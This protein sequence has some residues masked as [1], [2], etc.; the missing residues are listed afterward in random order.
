[1]TLSEKISQSKAELKESQRMNV[2]LELLTFYDE[3]KK[4]PSDKSFALTIPVTIVAANESFFKETF[5]GLIDFD[6]KFLE[7]AKILI[8]KAGIKFELDELF[9]I[10]KSSFSLGD[11][12]SYTLKYSSIESLLKTFQVISEIDIFRE[13]ETFDASMLEDINDM[14]SVQRPLNK[15]RI[16]TNLKEAYEIRNIICHDFLSSTHKLELDNEKLA[17]F[18]LDAALLQYAIDDI[19]SDKIYSKG[20]PLEW[21]ER[22]KYFQNKVEERQKTLDSIYDAIRS[23]LNSDIQK[24]NLDENIKAF[25]NF[26]INDSNDIGRFWFNEYD[27]DFPFEDLA[28]EYK[29]KLLDQRIKIL[30][31]EI[32]SS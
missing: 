20:I 2:S 25:K 17:N 26:L 10:S 31:G 16:I 21:E 4:R 28:L 32:N 7:N 3:L 19:L 15:A 22:I 24:K 27:E 18:I 6:K 1:M 5:S 14:V 12:I 23:S 29:I 13:L 30:Q 8:K 9:H 11:L